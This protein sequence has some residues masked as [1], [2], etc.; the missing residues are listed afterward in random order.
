MTE[1]SLAHTCWDCAYQVVWI[2]KYRKKVLYGECRE[3]LKGILR[4][5]LEMK[6]I[7]MVEGAIG[8]GHIH[9]SVRIPPKEWVS[10]IMGYLKRKSDLMLL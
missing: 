7:G 4:Q 2:P 9:L 10:R 1:Q 3:E 6:K 5:L 8:K